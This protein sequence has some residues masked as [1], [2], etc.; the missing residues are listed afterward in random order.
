MLKFYCSAL[1]ICG[2]VFVVEAQS[3]PTHRNVT[4]QPPDAWQFMKYGE[5]PVSKETGVPNINIP[6]YTIT[7]GDLSVP[8]SLSYHASGIKVDETASWVGLGWA[9]NAGGM[10]SRTIKGLADESTSG[11]LFMEDMNMHYFDAN[12]VI[13]PSKINKTTNTDYDNLMRMRSRQ[14]DSDPDVF[15]YN[16]GGVA[17]RFFLDPT[18]KSVTQCM[19]VTTPKSD[20]KIQAIIEDLQSGG[21]GSAIDRRITKIIA[22][23]PD[24]TKYIFDVVATFSDFSLPTGSISGNSSWYL[25]EIQSPGSTETIQFFYK[26]FGGQVEDVHTIN[27][28]TLTFTGPSYEASAHPIVSYPGASA[29]YT[30]MKVLDY[31]D[32]P[33]GRVVFNSVDDRLDDN[34]KRL[35]S[36]DIFD[37]GQPATLIKSYQLDNNHYFVN[38][39]VPLSA[40]P[41]NDKRLK[42]QGVTEVGNGKAN[43]PYEFSYLETGHYML[44]SR[45]STAQDFWGYYNGKRLNQTLI[46]NVTFTWTDVR[47]TTEYSLGNAS[48]DADDDYMKAGIISSIKYPTGG[49]TDFK[50]NANTITRTYVKTLPPTTTTYDAYAGYMH[51]YPD[52]LNPVTLTPD[53]DMTVTVNY[54]I[55]CTASSCSPPPT[56]PN[57]STY[58]SMT[59][60][61]VDIRYEDKIQSG[62]ITVTLTAGSTYTLR[63]HCTAAGV[64]VDINVP[65]SVPGGSETVT[66]NAIIGG[67]RIANISNFDANGK[68]V[69]QQNYSYEDY[70]ASTV[71]GKIRHASTGRSSG[72]YN[73]QALPSADDF[74]TI[75]STVIGGGVPSGGDDL[76]G[77]YPTNCPI[78]NRYTYAVSEVAS[79]QLGLPAGEVIT[80]RYVTETLD[81]LSNHLNGKTIY[82]YDVSNTLLDEEFSLH[83]I[84]FVLDRGWRRGQL[85]G[86]Y[87]YDKNDQLVKEV[88]YSYETVVM[89]GPVIRGLKVDQT[90]EVENGSGG[91]CLCPT[92]SEQLACEDPVTHAIPTDC[93]DCTISVLRNNM[94]F[95]RTY[96][97]PIEWKR[98]VSQTEMLDNVSTTTTFEYDPGFAHTNVITTQTVNSKNEIVRHEVR[99]AKETNNQLLLGKNMVGIPLEADTKLQGNLIDGSKLTYTSAN[100]LILPTRFDKHLSDGSYLFESEIKSVTPTGKL[101]EYN[102]LAGIKNSFIWG[103]NDSY[104]IAKVLNA[105]VTDIFHTSFEDGGGVIDTNSKTGRQVNTTGYST[106]LANLDNGNYILS[107]WKRSN[108]IWTP[109]LSNVIIANNSYQLTIAATTAEPIDEIRFYPVGAQMTTFTFDPLIGMTS[110]T[111]PNNITSYFSYDEM[112]RFNASMDNN[113]FILKTLLYHFQN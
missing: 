36:I 10:I 1:L 70:T 86:E 35:T 91:V 102:T 11:L 96:T 110:T 83:N 18:T 103:Y 12:G 69:N 79:N 22:Q 5:Y 27:S 67:L 41:T 59:G 112:R 78:T 75:T 71:Q 97:E 106:F 56:I 72:V 81:D 113:G 64:D 48:R 40:I 58:V 3:D 25:S 49:R 47:G 14:L 28:T 90:D 63:A 8:I 104:V 73:I 43:P 2:S 51:G 37:K 55:F 53:R 100:G 87:Y 17:G 32:F 46:P 74:L 76:P 52:N 101:A 66:E 42:L 13:D 98:L 84:S 85:L 95:L 107:Y 109:S 33:S 68:K 24:G 65:M 77:I 80:Y 23:T 82:H 62:S 4:A 9:L 45:H 21:I 30:G 44:P 34:T 89:D 94:V 111:D 108:G 19:G 57:N 15:N 31:I 93:T 60:P 88:D 26:D 99:Y 50:F 61:G 39:D 6:I 38:T 20:V 29:S 7:A 105:S 16:F 54:N 92:I